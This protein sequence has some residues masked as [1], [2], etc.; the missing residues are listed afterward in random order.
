MKRSLD[1]GKDRP[2]VRPSSACPS[3]PAV[4]RPSVGLV[5][6]SGSSVHP[7]VWLPVRPSGHPSMPLV[8]PSVRLVVR[9]SNWFSGCPS[10]RSFCCTF[11]K[12]TVW[13]YPSVRLVVGPFVW[14]P[15]WVSVRPFGCLSVCP[16]CMV[17]RK[18][19]RQADRHTHTHTQTSNEQIFF[20]RLLKVTK[21]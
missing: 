12:L 3:V 16:F 18:K 6:R 9:P 4:V 1:R 13:L 17:P 2:S 20:K 19:K 8:R 10:V 14:A 7:S 21:S 5:R 11:A 15:V